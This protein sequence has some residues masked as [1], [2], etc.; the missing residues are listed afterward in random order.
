MNILEIMERIPH[1]YPFLLVDRMIEME[2]GKRGIGIKNITINEAF[3]QGH[4]PISPVMPGVLIVEALA[5]VG[6][7]VVLSL[8][9]NK[10]KLAYF[11]GIDKFRFRKQV[12]PGDQLLLEIEI[13][14]IRGNMGRGIG[15][16]TVD[17]TLVA[18]GGIMFALGNG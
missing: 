1:R 8:E 7:I 17:G 10:G 9:E 5:Q 12:V 18:E 6:A 4:F 16:A 14:K 3:F 11:A 2:P 15:K 13:T